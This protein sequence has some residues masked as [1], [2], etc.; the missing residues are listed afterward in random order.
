M[1]EHPA[2]FDPY[3]QLAA[4]DRH[5]VTYILIGAF[6][7]IVQGTE[8]LTRGMDIVPSTR[9]ENL[10]RLGQALED[11]HARGPGLEEERAVFEFATDRGELKVVPEPAGT[12]GYDDL[13]RAAT[14]QPLGRGARPS[15]ASTGDLARM[16][17]ALGREH[18][19]PKLLQLRHVMELERGLVIER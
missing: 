19:I 10:R 14:R 12:R 3:G 7:R 2:R 15:V 16:V 4:L 13:R 5:R 18:E 17:A 9:T 8:E 6:A 1:P 11:L